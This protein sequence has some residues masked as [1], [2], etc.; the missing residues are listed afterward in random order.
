MEDDPTLHL[1]EED[2]Q[3]PLPP[4]HMLGPGTPGEQLYSSLYSKEI[5]MMRK[6]AGAGGP[7]E[8]LKFAAAGFPRP[9]GHIPPNM[10][11][12]NMI[13]NPKFGQP[14]GGGG[15]AQSFNF[16][17]PALPNGEPSNSHL[18]KMEGLLKPCYDDGGYN[19]HHTGHHYPGH[20]MDPNFVNNFKPDGVMI[21]QEAGEPSGA[22]FGG[23]K[24]QTNDVLLYGRSSNGNNPNSS[25]SSGGSN[26][27]SK[28]P[29][30]F[31]LNFSGSNSAGGKPDLDAG[32][33]GADEH[34]DK[35]SG[36]ND[37]GGEP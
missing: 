17:Q 16:Q 8:E 20:L 27:S 5:G 25:C 19:F 18:H 26:L 3:L 10:I 13:Y 7:E 21:K 4:R 30:E 36:L 34:L 6:M 33:L 12:E 15:G 9:G 32:D 37:S 23:V 35:L 29:N 2:R 31:N 11:P 22:S 28:E 14:S 24:Q 1:L